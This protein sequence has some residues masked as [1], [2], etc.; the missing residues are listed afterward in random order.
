M[1]L[2]AGW[3]FG[4]SLSLVEEEKDS[5]GG[6]RSQHLWDKRMTLQAGKALH[7]LFSP[8]V[9]CTL[10]TPLLAQTF[11]FRAVVWITVIMSSSEGPRE[12]QSCRV[13]FPGLFSKLGGG[14]RGC[15]SRN[16]ASA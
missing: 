13:T 6:P 12:A 14:E 4:P 2:R 9:A 1:N 16:Q 5:P 3:D 15:C 8:Q 7:P 10:V 11:H